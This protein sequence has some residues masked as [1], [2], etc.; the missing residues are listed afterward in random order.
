[1]GRVSFAVVLSAVLAGCARGPSSDA[2]PPPPQV[3]TDRSLDALGATDAGVQRGTRA[4][5][6]ACG[7]T[8]GQQCASGIC[9][10]SQRERGR[11][12]FCSRECDTQDDCPVN[13]LCRQVMPGRHGMM[14]T[15]PDRWTAQAVGVRP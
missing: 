11:G 15:P 14:C 5:G 4:L 2:P 10:K 3:F 1:M 6:A 8:A 13:W 7:S 9:L 12:Y